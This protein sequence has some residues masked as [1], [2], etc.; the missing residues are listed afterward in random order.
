M[1]PTAG[2]ANPTNPMPSKRVDTSTQSAFG[3]KRAQTKA[4]LRAS[5][6]ADRELVD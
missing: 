6:K 5:A 4:L 3:R 2:F 1:P